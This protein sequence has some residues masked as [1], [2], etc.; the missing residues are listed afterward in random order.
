MDSSSTGLLL[1]CGTEAVPATGTEG[2]L[3]SGTVI[4]LNYTEPNI[5]AGQS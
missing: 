1:D 5:A 4:L 2:V 3:D